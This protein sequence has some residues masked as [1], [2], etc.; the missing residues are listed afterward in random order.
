[1]SGEKRVGVGCHLGRP[2]LSRGTP[3]PKPKR[4]A[5]CGDGIVWAEDQLASE[6]FRR[7]HVANMK[8]RRLQRATQRPVDWYLRRGGAWE[9]MVPRRDW[10]GCPACSRI[11][12]VDLEQRLPFVWL[13]PP[14]PLKQSRGV[15]GRATGDSRESPPAVKRWGTWHDATMARRSWTRGQSTRPPTTKRQ[16]AKQARQGS[17]RGSNETSSRSRRSDR[18]QPTPRCHDGRRGPRCRPQGGS[19]VVVDEAAAGGCQASTQTA[20]SGFGQCW[21]SEGEAEENR[22]SGSGHA[23]FTFWWAASSASCAAWCAFQTG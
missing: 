4:G 17:A 23:K 19:V 18:M 16:G 20:G 5:V 11:P 9:L 12:R 15:L 8:P 13:A 14:Q 10:V 6:H 2:L 21:R 7:L 1:M 22:Q 3:K